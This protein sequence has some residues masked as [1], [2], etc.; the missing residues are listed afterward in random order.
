VLNIIQNEKSI[1]GT[2]SYSR[3]ADR[4]QR[5][6]DR[7]VLLQFPHQNAPARRTEQ[8]GTGKRPNIPAPEFNTIEPETPLRLDVAV[9]LG[10][11]AGGMT[12]SGLRGEARR[13]RLRIEII[14]NKQF[15]TLAAIEE[16]REL[17]RVHQ[18]ELDCGS[19]PP[20]TR[21][22]RSSAIQHG[23]SGTDHVKSARAALEKTANGL[24]RH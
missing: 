2:K 22:A 16:M 12:V 3:R 9:K 6:T 11:P 20:S 18:K 4:F 19:N 5:A 21:T 10:F 14:A 1:L 15:T 23:S 17:C 7:Q 24:N 8:L 13:G